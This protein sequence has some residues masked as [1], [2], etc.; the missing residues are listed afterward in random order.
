MCSFLRLTPPPSTTT[1]FQFIPKP[2]KSAMGAYVA[3][4]LGMRS[5]GGVAA[6]ERDAVA[7]PGHTPNGLEEAVDA[8]QL[9]AQAAAMELSFVL[10]KYEDHLGACPGSGQELL[11]SCWCWIS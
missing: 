11:R 9:E 6:D 8:H 4:W 7:A 2:Q 5:G 3:Y 1:V 10:R